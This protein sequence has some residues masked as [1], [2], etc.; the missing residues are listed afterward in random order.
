MNAQN[1]WFEQ[2]KLRAVLLFSVAC[3]FIYLD[4]FNQKYFKNTKAVINDVVA[5]SSY[6]ITWPIKEVLNVPGYV[7]HIVT[8]N[9]ENEQIRI[10][11]E[12]RQKLIADNKFLRQKNQKTRRFIQEEKLY[13]DE[14]IP[15]KVILRVNAITA[16]S[17]TI[18]KGAGDGIKI[19]NPVVKNN[20]LIGQVEEVN[21]KSSRVK[22]L[23]DINSNI[24]VLVGEFLTQAIFS[25]D[26]SSKMKFNIEYLPKNFRLKN[27]DDI[28]TSDI[29]GILKKGILIGTVSDAKYDDSTKKQSYSINF[30]YKLHQTD[31]V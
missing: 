14:A 15:A 24:P 19:G 10:L 11:Q 18:N 6:I 4:N 12:E 25:G 27:G 2:T 29:D 17:M 9:K 7:M 8:L 3:S 5:H 31:Y 20:N 30:N 26:P 21:Y 28:Y 23:S 16:N 13:Q 22:L 1:S